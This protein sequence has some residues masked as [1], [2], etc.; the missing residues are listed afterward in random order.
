MLTATILV[1]AHSITLEIH[2]LRHETMATFPDKEG[3][4]IQADSMLVTVI[5]QKAISDFD[6]LTDVKQLGNIFL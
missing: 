3:M 5:L 6:I 2:L 1:A 4:W